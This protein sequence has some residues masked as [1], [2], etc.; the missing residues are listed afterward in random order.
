VLKITIKVKKSINKKDKLQELHPMGFSGLWKVYGKYSFLK[1]PS[2]YLSFAFCLLIFAVTY[3]GDFD[4]KSTLNLLNN[5]IEVGLSLDGGLL[6]LTLAGLTLI[7]TFGSDRLLKHMVKINV[8]N[9]L[10][11]NRE[12]GFSSYQTAVSKFAFAVFV[13]VITLIVLFIFSLAVNFSFSFENEKY[14]HLFNCIYLSIA[15]FLVLY[16]L[17]LVVQMTI[18][19]FTISQMN[20]AVY[21]SDSVF[22]VLDKKPKE[23]KPEQEN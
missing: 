6:G 16:S 1:K 7:V 21:F 15:V 3:Y 12:I 14:N 5:V 2:F 11:N 4:A 20:H 13:Q 8:E 9:A 22:E 10:E 17:S 19:I 18:N 23:I